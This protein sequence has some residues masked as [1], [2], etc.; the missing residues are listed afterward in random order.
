MGYTTWWQKGNT[1]KILSNSE[2]EGD[3]NVRK[4]YEETLKT[5]FHE[6]LIC[7]R[8]EL[9]LTQEETAHRLA[10]GSRS[11]ADLDKGK[12]GCGGLTLARYLIYICDDPGIFLAELRCAF[13]DRD[14]HA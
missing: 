12:N 8:Y 5:F 7:R 3:T 1:G 11:Y 13:E 9:G 6:R 2:R 10:M 4:Q 14:F